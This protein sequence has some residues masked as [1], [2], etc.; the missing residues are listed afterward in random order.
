MMPSLWHQK[1]S[2]LI[3][4]KCVLHA[5]PTT[6]AAVKLLKTA[7]YIC[8][9]ALNGYIASTPISRQVGK[10]ILP[11]DVGRLL[12]INGMEIAAHSADIEFALENISK[13][14]TIVMI[15]AAGRSRRHIGDASITCRGFARG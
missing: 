14:M 13:A 2:Y 12:E 6:A 7:Q 5:Q 3:G 9:L 8:P 4:R 15:Q 11:G 1:S 10:P